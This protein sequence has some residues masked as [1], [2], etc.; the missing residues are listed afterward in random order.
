MNGRD[1]LRSAARALLARTLLVDGANA[2]ADPARIAAVTVN[3]LYI[4]LSTTGFENSQRLRSMHTKRKNAD[5]RNDDE[6]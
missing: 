2:E 6:C 5:K 1:L 3:A 4:L